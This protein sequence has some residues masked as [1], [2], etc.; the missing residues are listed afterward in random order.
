MSD[1]PSCGTPDCYNS[2]FTVECVNSACVHFSVK[3]VSDFIVR[4]LRSK[5]FNSHVAPLSFTSVRPS[6]LPMSTLSSTSSG[7]EPPWLKVYTR[8]YKV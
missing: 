3:Q 5:L 8:V 6:G 4:E 1:C 2:G 7:I